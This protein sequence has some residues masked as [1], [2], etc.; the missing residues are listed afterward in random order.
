M[1]YVNTQLCSPLS[2]RKVARK[3]LGSKQLNAIKA[4]NRMV[5]MLAEA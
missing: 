2:N 5:T 4:L 1:N 3:G